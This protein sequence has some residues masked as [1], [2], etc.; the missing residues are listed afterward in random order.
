MTFGEE[1]KEKRNKLG[2]SQVSTAEFLDV[3]RATYVKWED[4]SE[5]PGKLKKAGAIA[6]LAKAKASDMPKKSSRNNI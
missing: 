1:L 6:I 4:G 2:W 5:D 3:S